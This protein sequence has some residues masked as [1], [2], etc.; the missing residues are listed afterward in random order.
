MRSLGA[1]A[2]PLYYVTMPQRR[3]ARARRRGAGTQGAPRQIDRSGASSRTRS[4]ISAAA[5]TLR[6][7][8]CA[9]GSAGSSRRCAVIARRW[10]RAIRSRGSTSTQARRWLGVEQFRRAPIDT[11][12]D[13]CSNARRADGALRAAG[14]CALTRSTS[15]AARTAADGSRS[16]TAQFH[17]AR[18]RRPRRRHSRLPLLRFP[19]RRRH[20][21]AAPAAVGG[22][23]ARRISTRDVPISR[24]GRCSSSRTTRI[25]GAVQRGGRDRTG[26]PIAT[27]STRSA[28]TF[29]GGYFLYRF[30][31]PT[32]VVAQAVV[33]AVGGTVL[34]DGG[35]AD[36]HLR[37]LGP[38]D[39]LAARPLVAGAGPCRP[40]FLEDVARP[41]VHG[42]RLRGGVLR[43]ELADAVRARRV[44]LRH[45]LRCLHVHLDEAA[46]RAARCC[47]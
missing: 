38:S 30:S 13:G 39:P 23:G 24:C 43:R 16:S 25:G 5:P 19:G 3:D 4:V 22:D 42:A 26:P 15:S 2:P 33:R 46:V 6:R 7:R 17:H 47:G 9:T 10:A 8:R 36:R 28:P 18:W 44:P 37:R 45:V 20:S 1:D 34:A 12:R 11:S 31:D 32:F 40:V 35:R 41:P 29:E 21:R 14:R 27:S